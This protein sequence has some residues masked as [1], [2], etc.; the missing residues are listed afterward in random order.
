MKLYLS[1]VFLFFLPNA[2]AIPLADSSPNI[3]SPNSLV[4]RD[5]YWNEL[6]KREAAKGKDKEKDKCPTQK[7]IAQ[8]LCTSGA[9]YCCSGE[10][11]AQVC[12]PASTT[13]CQTMTI[14]CINT[15]GVCLPFSSPMIGFE[16]VKVES[17][18]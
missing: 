14:C 9:P 2:L 7:P 15:N 3:S 17:N 12:G 11:A 18:K 5:A 13:T 4:S 16:S 10:G 1:A 8:N 6:D